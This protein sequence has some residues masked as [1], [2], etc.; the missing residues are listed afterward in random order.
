VQ[1]KAIGVKAVIAKS[2]SETSHACFLVKAQQLPLVSGIS[3][4]QSQ[5]ANIEEPLI[6]VDAELGRVLV[7]PADEDQA[8]LLKK[9]KEDQRQKE[10]LLP[11]RDRKTQTQ[12]GHPCLLMANIGGE[13]DLAAALGQGAEGIGLFRT[14]FLFMDRAEAP[15]LKEQT[16]VYQRVLA[17]MAPKPVLF[18]SLDVGGDKPISYLPLAA[19]ENPFLG[20]RGVRVYEQHPEIFLTQIR[21]LLGAAAKNPVSIMIPMIT[22]LDEILASKKLIY[23]LCEELRV[24]PENVHFGVMLETPVLIWSLGE[25]LDQVDFV[26][27]GTNDLLQ[28]LT[29]SDRNQAQ[30]RVYYNWKN[31]GFLKALAHCVRLC[32]EKNKF[33]GVCG[34]LAEKRELVPAWIA[35]GVNELSLPASSIL[36]TRA[37]IAKWTL[38][39]CEAYAEG[40]LEQKSCAAVKEYV[41]DYFSKTETKSF[42]NPTF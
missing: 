4:L 8:A 9:Q 35:W 32:R 23:N 11:F 21:A 5:L 29:A 28:Y 41:Q 24:P 12:D 40:L 19:E 37:H 17:A 10:Q 38:A 2:L 3:I 1:L 42:L 31:P 14:E 25:V 16:G 33:I 18:R 34:S 20:I 15:S 13:K 30:S 6:A 36:S 27:I 7:N 22:S 39:N 26:S